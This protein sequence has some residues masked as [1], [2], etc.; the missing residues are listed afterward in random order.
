CVSSFSPP[1]RSPLP[2]RPQRPPNRR[3]ISLKRWT[4][5]LPAACRIPARSRTWPMSPAVPPRP[6]STCRSAASSRRS[7]PPAAST[8]TARSARFRA[9]RIC[10]SAF[11][12]PSMAPRSASAASCPRWRWSPLPFA[13][14]LRTWSATSTA[15]STAA[16]TV[17]ATI[18][19]ITNIAAV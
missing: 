13:A 1:P 17:A 8:G 16:A 10:A 7:I 4:M 5:K 9:I 18:T 14:R 2:F 11:A 12:I 6:C 19:T 15:R 3:P